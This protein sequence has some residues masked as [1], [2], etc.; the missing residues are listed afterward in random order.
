MSNMRRTL[1]IA[2]GALLVLLVGVATALFTVDPKQLVGPVLARVKAATGRDVTV[3]GDVELRIGVAPSL[4][5]YDVRVGN[6]PWGKAPQLLSA[7]QLEAQVALLPL[8]RR[9]FELVR[10][11]LV[12]PVIALETNSDGRGNWELGAAPGGTAAAEAPST[13]GALAIG[14]LTING[15]LLTHRDALGGAETRVAIDELKLAA[16]DAKSPVE[17]EFR[18]AVDGTPVALTA[19]LGPLAT[20]RERRLPYPVAAKGD[21]AGRKVTMAVE[22]L[23]A[24]RRVE[25]QNLD[26]AFGASDVKGHVEV[27]DDGARSAWTISLASSALNLDDLPAGRPMAAAAKAAAAPGSSRFVFTE[28]AISFDALR[29]RDAAGELTI[30]RLTM[31]GGRTL[32]RMHGKFTLRDGKLAVPALQASGYGGAISGALTVDATRGRTPAISLRLDGRDLDLAGLLAAVGVKHE[33]RGGKTNVGI[34]VTMHGDSPHRWMSSVSGNARAVVG[35]ATL[36][37]TRLDPALTFDRLAEA[38]NPFRTVKPTTDLRCAVIRLPLTAGVA[39]IDRSI[40]METGEIDA[41]MSGTVDFRS[42]TIDLSIRPRV[43]RGIAVEF[44]QIAELVRFRGPFLAPTVTVDAVASAAAVAHIGA[45]IGTGGL[46]A[47]GESIFGSS[48]AGAGACDVALG[49][50]VPASAPSAKDTPAGA[51][52]PSVGNDLGKALERLFRR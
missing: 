18:G 34:D 38:V 25:L 7:K 32:E 14:D 28:T 39:R 23:R 43:R 19:S 45:A 29:A 24:D 1:G 31:T 6:A 42:E 44:P 2:G 9:H 17:A 47:L 20:L 8:L 36:V 33:V 46:S 16:R 40:A 12:E 30:G 15:G 35:P 13:P 27:R 52:T 21:I 48:S 10:L 49:K 3:G 50:A 5:A 37:N 22:I 11:N 26:L 51:G 4:V 41:S